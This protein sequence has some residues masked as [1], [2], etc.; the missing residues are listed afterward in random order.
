MGVSD[1][2]QADRYARIRQLA[3][4]NLYP[5][6]YS[7]DIGGGCRYIHQLKDN[8]FNRL[9]RSG[10]TTTVILERTWRTV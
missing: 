4:Q 1:Y 7:L 9:V 3:V 8:L 6:P 10:G 5:L 2:A